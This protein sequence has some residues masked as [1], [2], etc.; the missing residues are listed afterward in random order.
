MTRKKVAIVTGA[1]TGVG[2][3]IVER[4][5]EESNEPLII[6]LACRNKQRAYEAL[7]SLEA[8]FNKLFY[9][10]QPT[11]T[12]K[13]H[14]VKKCHYPE[15]KVELVDVSS[16]ASVT[17]FNKR[18]REQYT[19][20]DLLFCNAGVLPSAGIKWSK[21]VTDLFMRPMDLVIRSDVLVQPKQHLTE[22][23]IGNV[24]AANVF[25]H[26]L[27]IKGLE[28][29]LSKTEEDPGRVIWTSSMTAEK[30]S[31]DPSDWQGLEAV[32]PYESS[33]WVTDLLA[34]RLNE[35][36]ASGTSLSRSESLADISEENGQTITR[37]VTRSIS[38]AALDSTSSSKRHIM[39][40]STQPGVVASGIGGLAHWIVML[41][42]ALHYFVRIC[43]EKNQTITG[44]HAALPNVYVA[45]APNPRTTLDYYNKYGSQVGRFGREIL[46]V[47]TIV[48]YDRGQAEAVVA[49]LE[50][51]RAKVSQE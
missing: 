32:A 29:Q 15:L 16:V 21:V 40:I 30:S 44:Y 19:T 6:V 33:K 17:E 36:W 49:E 42:I 14:P 43:G 41:R 50:K 31:F 24:L 10:Q 39:S 12:K 51:L 20:I 34:I 8:H 13:N 47:E 5:V 11:D 18:M 27:M 22:D 35:V 38:K 2:Y 45:L 28:D 25:G 26:F 46:K 4:L 7:A 37:R 3:S 48:E 23:G 9:Q 1:N